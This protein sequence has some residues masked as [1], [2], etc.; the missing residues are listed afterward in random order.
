[1]HSRIRKANTQM[2]IR[3]PREL[4]DDWTVYLAIIGA[5]VLIV[6]LINGLLGG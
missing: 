4:I 2:K 5:A 1:M 6:A 3:I